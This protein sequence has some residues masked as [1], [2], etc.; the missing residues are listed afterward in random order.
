M[1]QS[2]TFIAYCSFTGLP[3]PT[4]IW[5]FQGII[6]YNSSRIS[7]T[8]D[9]QSITVSSTLTITN[10]NKSVDEGL[11]TCRGYQSGDLFYRNFHYSLLIEGK[12]KII[13]HTL[14]LVIWHL[15]VCLHNLFEVQY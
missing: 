9:I 10:V 6:L 4:I 14:M 3:L 5:M 11:Y 8:T 15:Y 1:N 7:I 12:H 13:I 2:D